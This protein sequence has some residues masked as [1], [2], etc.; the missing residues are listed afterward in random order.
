MFDPAFN[1]G[2]RPSNELHLNNVHCERGGM[3]ISGLRTQ[4]G[5]AVQ[6]P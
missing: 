1:D 3:H 6:R 4:R 2:P 5:P